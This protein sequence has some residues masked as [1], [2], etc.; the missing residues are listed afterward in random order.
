TRRRVFSSSGPALW[1]LSPNSVNAFHTSTYSLLKFSTDS[2]SCFGMWSL[3]LALILEPK[4]ITRVLIRKPD[5]LVGYF[6]RTTRAFS[7]CDNYCVGQKRN[8]KYHRTNVSR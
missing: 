3:L 5:F 6:V 7:C 4:I 2:G 8:D 1:H